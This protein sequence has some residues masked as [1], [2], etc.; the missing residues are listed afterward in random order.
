MPLEHPFGDSLWHLLLL[1][2]SRLPLPSLSPPSHLTVAC[3]SSFHEWPITDK[4]FRAAAI[5]AVP[6]IHLS[7][8]YCSIQPDHEFFRHS[9]DSIR[10]ITFQI[11]TIVGIFFFHLHQMYSRFLREWLTTFQFPQGKEAS[12]PRFG[13]TICCL[14]P[15]TSRQLNRIFLFSLPGGPKVIRYMFSPESCLEVGHHCL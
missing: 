7:I 6:F 15:G 5:I 14:G 10:V 9:L 12:G 2:R 1:E 4:V 8:L 11:L 3:P 13:W